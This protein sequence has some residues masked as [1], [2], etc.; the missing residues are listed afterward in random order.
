MRASLPSLLKKNFLLP[1]TLLLVSGC[2]SLPSPQYEPKPLP[3]TNGSAELELQWQ[4]HSGAGEGWRGYQLAPLLDGQRLITADAQGYLQTFDLEQGFLGFD[5]ML[6]T[7][8][9]GVGVSAGLTLNNNQLL[10]ATQN[11]ELL[12]LDANSGQTLWSTQVSSEALAPPQ[13]R[14]DLLILQTADGKLHA[15]SATSGRTLWSYDS[16][17]PNLTL[18][19]T[20]TPTLTSTQTLAGFANG[21]LA[22]IDNNS[23][24]LR[25]S[26]Q[27]AQP[28]GRTDIE[29]LVDVDGQAR[30]AQGLL[31]VNSYQGQTQA[32]DPYSGRSRWSRDLS[33]Y[34]A[35]LLIDGQVILVDEASRVHALDLATGSSLWTQDEL[36]G[37]QLTEAVLLEDQLVVADYQGYLHL[38]DPATGEITGREAFDLD[39]IRTPPLVNED[40]LLVHSIRGRI[41]L[42][43]LKKD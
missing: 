17:I 7:R 39:G 10:V 23:G 22:A 6:W 41:G 21:K 13:V 19:G 18:R 20:A 8:E 43:T 11:G 38:L 3:D 1:L 16:L 36:Y 15:F 29:R 40:R 12:S 35:P 24:Q 26:T 33:S 5:K 34:H 9:L 28:Q 4:D 32:L 25:W 37:R 31:I 27:I 42:F 14:G 30:M 2:S